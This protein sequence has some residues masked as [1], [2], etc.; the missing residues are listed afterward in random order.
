ME[1]ARWM[2]SENWRISQVRSSLEQFTYLYLSPVHSCFL[3]L[4]CLICLA[5]MYNPINTVISIWR[6][7]KDLPGTFCSYKFL[8]ITDNVPI[9]Y[10]WKKMCNSRRSFFGG[11]F[12]TWKQVLCGSWWE[13]C[14]K[15]RTM[16]ISDWVPVGCGHDL[17]SQQNLKWLCIMDFWCYPEKMETINWNFMLGNRRMEWRRNILT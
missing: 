1:I 8:G 13:L 12:S 5:E 7:T 2:M 6:V 17:N 3:V 16:Q 14:E 10:K 9:K 11:T 15:Q 4:L